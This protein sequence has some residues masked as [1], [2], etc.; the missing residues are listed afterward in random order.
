MQIEKSVFRIQ[1]GFQ[2]W[3]FSRFVCS[4]GLYLVACFLASCTSYARA[5][6]KPATVKARGAENQN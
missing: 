3:N 1:G 4:A 5:I 2:K 6:N